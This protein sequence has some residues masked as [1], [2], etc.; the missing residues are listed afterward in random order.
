MGGHSRLGPIKTNA[1]ATPVYTAGFLLGRRPP[2][3]R[4]TPAKAYPGGSTLMSSAA[5]MGKRAAL[6]AKAYT[7]RAH[8]SQMS[9]LS[10]ME[11]TLD[12]LPRPTVD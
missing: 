6:Y 8:G 12:A 3:S 11:K 5:E 4:Y 9:G 7:S 10:D 1:E 2:S